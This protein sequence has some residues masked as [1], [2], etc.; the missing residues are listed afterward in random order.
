M[1]IDLSKARIFIRP[2]STDLRKAVNGLAV[3]IEQKMKSEVFNGDVYLFCNAERKLLKALWW[4]KSG[5]WLCQK[6]LE[7]AKFPWPKT[8][9]AVKELSRDQL[10]M[11]LDGIDF[12]NAHKTLYYK[13]VS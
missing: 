10:S 5:F 1:T 6:R 7:Q 2:G 9:E 4:D 11:L 13:K 8:I 12:F 3:I